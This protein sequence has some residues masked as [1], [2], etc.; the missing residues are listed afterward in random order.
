MKLSEEIQALGER[1]LR[2]QEIIALS[3][4]K[5]I[6]APEHLKEFRAIEDDRLNRR[7][8]LLREGWEKLQ[9]LGYK[10]YDIRGNAAYESG[11]SDVIDPD[12]NYIFWGVEAPDGTQFPGKAQWT[13]GILPAIQHAGI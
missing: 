5:G 4:I 9:A 1:S 6:I 8:Q 7:K 12:H 11:H 3:P 2:E 10:K 13:E